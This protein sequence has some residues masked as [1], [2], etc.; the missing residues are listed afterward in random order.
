MAQQR[1]RLGAVP[2]K[3][4]DALNITLSLATEEPGQKLAQ[5]DRAIDRGRL[6]RAA[7]AHHHQPIDGERY[8][9]GRAAIA[10]LCTLI[11]I[12]FV[13]SD[14]RTTCAI[15][16][17]SFATGVAVSILLIEC[18]SR[19]FTGGVSVRPVLLQQIISAE[20]PPTAGP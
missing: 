9:M 14:N 16:L 12:S 1:A 13:H 5:N 7:S 10:A 4:V 20:G 6:G 11:A 15:A 19:P 2:T 17:T 18:Y 3:L 8:Q